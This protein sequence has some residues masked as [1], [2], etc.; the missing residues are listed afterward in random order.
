MV[1]IKR[2]EKLKDNVNRISTELEIAKHELGIAR[3][4]ITYLKQCVKD[5]IKEFEDI[6]LSVNNLNEEDNNKKSAHQLLREYFYGEE[7]NK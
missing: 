3:E 7:E 4:E 6:K 5:L 1:R 2:K